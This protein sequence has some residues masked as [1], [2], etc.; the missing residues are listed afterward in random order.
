MYISL[1]QLLTATLA[2]SSPLA[3]ADSADTADTSAMTSSCYP[4][5]GCKTCESSNMINLAKHGCDFAWKN[6][7]SYFAGKY[8]HCT[9]NGGFESR[10]QCYDA[11]QYLTDC[12]F[13]NKKNG[14]KVGFPSSCY[15]LLGKLLTNSHSIPGKTTAKTAPWT[16]IFAAVPK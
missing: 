10:Q 12:H 6:P 13:K 7:P 15:I 2:L 8:G 5:G 4:S 16:L 9:F 1:S 14:A 11:W 3:S